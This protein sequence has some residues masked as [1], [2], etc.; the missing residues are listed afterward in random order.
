M[1]LSKI[2]EEN[3]RTL[4]REAI[5][6]RRTIQ[7]SNGKKVV[8]GSRRHL[9]E[10]DRIVNELDFLRKG[11][12]RKFRKERYT[13]SRCIESIRFLKRKLEREGIRSGLISEVD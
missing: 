4:I 5:G 6:S 8:E 10:L 12:G 13:I 3:L 11:M 1:S 2:Q 9:N 7:L